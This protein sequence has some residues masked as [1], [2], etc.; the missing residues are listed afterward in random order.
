VHNEKQKKRTKFPEQRLL[1]VNLD[2]NLLP[3]LLSR[4]TLLD[5]LPPNEIQNT[6]RHCGACQ[7][8][9]K[10]HGAYLRAVCLDSFLEMS[11]QSYSALAQCSI[12][13]RRRLEIDSRLR[14]E[15]RD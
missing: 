1:S 8:K 6:R 15:Y 2:M 12:Q 13:L 11:A 9:M 5:S 3:Q 10:T 4:T 14:P 7:E